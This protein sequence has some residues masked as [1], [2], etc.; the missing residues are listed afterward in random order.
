VSIKSRVKQLERKA[1]AGGPC[2][3]GTTW[4]GSYCPEDG[5][6]PPEVPEDAMRCPRCGEI[7]A[8]ILEEGIMRPGDVRPEDD[9]S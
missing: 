4:L 6:S 8:V 2:N 9:A 1:G 5:E 3:Y 7:H